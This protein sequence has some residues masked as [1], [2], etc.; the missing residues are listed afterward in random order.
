M[1]V[2]DIEEISIS[3]KNHG[4]K[5]VSL[6]RETLTNNEKI[7]ETLHVVTCISNICEFKRRWDLMKEFIERMENTKN[8]KL[9]VVELAYGLQEFHITDSTNLNHLQLRVNTALWHKENM[10]NLAI[11]K[12]LPSDWKAVAWIDG[13]IEFDNEDWVDYALKSLTKFDIIQLFSVCLDLDHNEDCLNIWQSFGY[14]FCNGKKFGFQRGV[15][16][17]HCGYAWA[18]TRD[19]YVKMNGLYEKC[20]LGSGD[21]VLS[22]ALLGNTASIDKNL[23]HLKEDI[24]QHYKNIIDDK[25][26]NVGYIPSVIKH[27]FHGSKVNRKYKER[28]EILKNIVYNP[29]IHISYNEDGIL[30]P[31][32]NMTEGCLDEIQEYFFQRNE[33][34]YFELIK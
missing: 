30:V 20:I 3:E 31:S 33:D 11:K 7:E 1:V 12:L 23:V 5:N 16:Y 14:R 25:K 4:I 8:V 32:E 2:L 13:D 26:I 10:L 22:Q 9:Y 21:F 19:F 27:Y 6:L 15:N 34:E 28:N 17:W 29:N 18:C 24:Y